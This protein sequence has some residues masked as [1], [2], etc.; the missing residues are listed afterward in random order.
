MSTPFP[1]SIPLRMP[2][3]IQPIFDDCVLCLFPVYNHKKWIDFTGHRNHGTIQ[4][5]TWKTGG[6]G[7]V[8]NFGGGHLVNCPD[9]ESLRISFALSL[10]AWVRPSSG[11]LDG[12][13]HPIAG[14]WNDNGVDKRAYMFS[15]DDDLFRAS[16]SSDGAWHSDSVYSSTSPSAGL[17]YHVMATFDGVYLR[18]FVNGDLEGGPFDAYGSGIAV[19]DEP[20]TIGGVQAGGGGWHYF[21]GDISEL[22]VFRRALSPEEVRRLYE[23]SLPR[24]R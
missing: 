13:Y 19:N 5:A 14:K 7:K 17:W 9:A 22:R 20:F 12:D 10:E 11:S 3:E 8:L 23:W 24:Y 16:V 21:Y 4:G 18:L 15:I 6:L 1:P 2:P